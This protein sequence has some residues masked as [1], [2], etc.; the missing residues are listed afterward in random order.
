MKIRI[1]TELLEFELNDEPTMT[2]DGYTKHAIPETIPAI[3]A[4]I[5]QAVIL[6]NAVKEKQHDNNLQKI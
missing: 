5:E 4:A 1:K 6:H 2:N 3:K